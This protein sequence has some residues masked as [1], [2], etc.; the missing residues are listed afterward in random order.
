M[1]ATL[2]IMTAVAAVACSDSFKPTEENVVGDYTL[3]MLMTTDTSGTRDWV[4]AGA[5]LTLTLD[6]NGTTTGH[7]HVP[8]AGVGGGDFDADMAGTWSLTGSTVTF[9]QTADTF[10]RDMDF[11]AGKNRLSGDQT[12]SSSTNPERVRIAMTK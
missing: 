1:R 8:G 9:D 7:L 12:F 4:A 2:I 6:T 10:M 11:T 3:Q 5:T